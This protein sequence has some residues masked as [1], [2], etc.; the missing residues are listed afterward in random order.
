MVTRQD[1]PGSHIL[2]AIAWHY[3]RQPNHKHS[4]F[5][6]AFLDGGL[7]FLVAY[8]E[9]CDDKS[10]ERLIPIPHSLR[11]RKEDE[12]LV[13][14]LE[15]TSDDPIKRIDPPIRQNR[16]TEIRNTICQDRA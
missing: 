14:L 7:R 2:G 8:P 5:R 3:L 13:H 15:K 1:I 12:E 6:T 10:K 16:S 9:A 11:Q 4:E